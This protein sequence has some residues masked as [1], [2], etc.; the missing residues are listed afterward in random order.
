MADQPSGVVPAPPGVTLDFDYSHPW[1]YNANM[2]LTG[3]GLVVSTA[4][5]LLR[6]YT[7]VHILRK[8]EMD[9]GRVASSR[10]NG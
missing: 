8:F 4:S 6:V 1:L 10:F 7:R 3:I 2:T 5:L 9:D